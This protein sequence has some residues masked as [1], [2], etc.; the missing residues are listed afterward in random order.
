MAPL[1]PWHWHVRSGL[2]FVAATVALALMAAWFFVLRGTPDL[3]ESNSIRTLWQ[4]TEEPINADTKQR[5][6]EQSI[7]TARMYPGTVGGVSCLLLALKYAPDTSAGQEA[8]N[9]FLRE[10]QTAEIDVIAGALDRSLGH[11]EAMTELAPA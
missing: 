2:A 6:A 3:R 11:W 10:L 1:I 9:I 4:S 8:R 5:F 7:K